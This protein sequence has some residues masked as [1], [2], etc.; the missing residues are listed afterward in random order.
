[1]TKF[2]I[3]FYK[4]I[5]MKFNTNKAKRFAK[6]QRSNALVCVYCYFLRAES[7]GD[8]QK[9]RSVVN[10]GGTSVKIDFSIAKRGNK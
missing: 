4:K 5:T 6:Q 10:S 2:V 1:M 9:N 8:H 3:F 7:N